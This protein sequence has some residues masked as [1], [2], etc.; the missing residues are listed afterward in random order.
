MKRKTWLALGIAAVL[1][2]SGA[3]FWFGGALDETVRD[4]MRRHDE[5]V[6][7]QLRESRRPRD[8]VLAADIER[9]DVGPDWV[10]RAPAYRAAVAKAAAAAP[11]DALVQWLQA[12]GDF[13]RT[14]EATQ[15]DTQAAARLAQSDPDNAVAW[16]LSVAD[17]QRRGDA[18]LVDDALAHMAQAARHDEHGDEYLLEMMDV[19]AIRPFPILVRLFGANADGLAF[20]H[21]FGRS[22]AL[23][24]PPYVALRIACDAQHAQGDATR[25]DRCAVIARRMIDS[26]SAM[27][28]MLGHTVLR[29]SGRAT[30]DDA[31]RLRR[32]EWQQSEYSRLFSEEMDGAAGLDRVADDWRAARSEVG[33]MRRLL[34]RHG[35]TAQTDPPAGWT[36]PARGSAP[37]GPDG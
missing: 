20:V 24:S 1:V 12:I 35:M 32:W 25:Y 36:P 22:A 31:A 10:A 7:S 3:V 30:P 37:A 21:A 16:T 18:V 5:A 11:N 33:A 17:A 23:D 28:V 14:R 13:Q 34:E 27:A 29:V 8:W 19:Y 6:A 15:A 4:M 2:V 9:G 26:D